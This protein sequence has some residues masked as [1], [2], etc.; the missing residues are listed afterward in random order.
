MANP[1]N[2]RYIHPLSTLS[3]LPYLPTLPTFHPILSYI[4]PFH[5]LHPL[6]HISYTLPYLH[7]PYPHILPTIPLHSPSLNL[8]SSLSRST[9]PI[10]PQSPHPYTNCPHHPIHALVT[11]LY[12]FIPS[13]ARSHIHPYSPPIVP[14]ETY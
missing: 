5:F 12:S 13:S 7:P 1:Q 10:Y 6:T 14:R 2:M 8:P 9:T 3:P 4:F 11:S